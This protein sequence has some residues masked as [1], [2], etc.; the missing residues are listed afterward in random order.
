M[1]RIGEQRDAAGKYT[2][3]MICNSVVVMSRTNDHFMAHIPRAVVAIVGIHDAV[4]MSVAF[5]AA[6]I[7]AVP[8]G[9]MAMTVRAFA[10]SEPAEN[11]A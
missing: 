4:R 10:K 1:D 3:T 7:M 6:M 8:A 11:F 2:T 5:A 9:T